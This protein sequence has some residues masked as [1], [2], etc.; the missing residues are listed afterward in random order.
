MDYSHPE[1]NYEY[2][3]WFP[4]TLKRHYDETKWLPAALK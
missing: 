4:I 3:K 2:T 1:G